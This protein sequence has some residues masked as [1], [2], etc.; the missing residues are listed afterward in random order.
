M[1]RQQNQPMPTFNLNQPERQNVHQSFRFL[2]NL[3]TNFNIGQDENNNEQ[4]SDFSKKML[5]F[6]NLSPAVTEKHLNKLFGL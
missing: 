4:S 2:Q 3:Q 5:Y 6:G 1:E